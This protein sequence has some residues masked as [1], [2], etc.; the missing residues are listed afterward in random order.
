MHGY[1]ERLNIVLTSYGYQIMVL[2]LNTDLTSRVPVNYSVAHIDSLVDY[3][4]D[5]I[6]LPSTGFKTSNIST[7]F[8]QN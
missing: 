2:T 3:A 5:F 4:Q 7:D 1:V 6:I 8:H